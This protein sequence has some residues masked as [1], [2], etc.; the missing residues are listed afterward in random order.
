MSL[1]VSLTLSQGRSA[2]AVVTNRRVTP[3]SHGPPGIA[4]VG[5]FEGVNRLMFWLML[6]SV[7]EASLSLR[8]PFSILRSSDR[9][10]NVGVRVTS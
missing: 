10:E 5:M 9:V 3:G 7:Y 8:F 1:V 6:A 2:P 4:F